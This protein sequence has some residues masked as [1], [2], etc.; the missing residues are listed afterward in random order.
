VCRK[1]CK[2]RAEDRRRAGLYAVGLRL[3][4]EQ[5]E[6]ELKAAGFAV[7]SGDRGFLPYQYIIK[8]E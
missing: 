6:A 1:A 5:V 2:D 7:L 4:Q 3:S 8:A